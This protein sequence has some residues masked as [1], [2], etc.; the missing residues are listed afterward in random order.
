MQWGGSSGCR[1]REL[2]DAGTRCRRG[3]IATPSDVCPE[4]RLLRGCNRILGRPAEGVASLEFNSES[5]AKKRRMAA[6]VRAV[7]AVSPISV[8][9]AGIRFAHR[10]GSHFCGRRES[11]GGRGPRFGSGRIGQRVLRC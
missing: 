8:G 10:R 9:G 1:L 2:R 7:S 6:S 3:G 4:K 5:G 11:S